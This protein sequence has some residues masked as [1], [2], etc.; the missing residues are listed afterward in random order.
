MTDETREKIALFR[1]RLISPVLAEPAR[2]QNEYF[3]TQAQKPHQ[4]PGRDRPRRFAVS[5]LKRYLKLYRKGGFEALKPKARADR[6]RPRR[7]QGE[8]WE[9]VK[10]LCAQHPY[11]SVRRLYAEL[12]AKDLLGTPPI[13]YNTLTRL[14]KKDGLL[15]APGRT[16]VRKRFERE[17][18]NELWLCDFMHGPQ[19]KLGPRS[20]KAILCAIIDDHSRLIVGHG[21]HVHETVDVLT[22]VLKEALGAYGLPKR[23]YAD[24][25][26][27]FSADLLTK[28][29]ATLGISL[30][31]SKPYDSPSRGK[32]ERFFRT[33]QQR[34]LPDLVG[35]PTLDE[36]NFT[37]SAWLTEHYQH[38]HHRGIDMKPIDRYQASAAKVD[39][40]R[41]SAAELDVAFLVRHERVVA[42][43]ATISF[44][45]RIYEVPAA[46]IRQRVDLR[47]PVG[48]P[49]ELLLFDN[50]EQIAQL[51][52]VN[53]RENARTFRPSEAADAV[54]FA[55][56]KVLP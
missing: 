55:D 39:I 43:D 35:Q 26:A 36:L 20:R 56:G 32:I 13:V 21:F 50:G 48:Q 18:V 2:Q 45:G 6:G 23:F 49:E 40:R 27:A 38:R 37:F 25:G 29:C 28:A 24:N 33:V 22:T 52:L 46:Y 16:D 10:Q 1:Y 41:L 4:V 31:H 19:V 9:A 47:H 30:I 8:A 5:T 11:W 3:R 17:A 7:L 53:L 44:Q 42:N 34:F 15:Q 14:V 51:K 12:A 54:S